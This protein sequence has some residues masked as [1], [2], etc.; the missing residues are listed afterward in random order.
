MSIKDELIQYCYRCLKD[1]YISEFE[2]Y[3]S[4]KKHKQSVERLLRDFERENTEGFP[5]YWDDEEAQKI[6]KWFTYLRHSKGELAGQPINLTVWQKFFVCQIYGWK[7]IDTFRRR[8]TKSFVEC[9]RKQAKSQMEAGIGLYEMSTTATKNNEITENYMTGVRKD[10]SKIIFEEMKLMLRGSSLE[11]RF[12]ISRDIIIHRKSGSLAKPLSKEDKKSGDGTNINLLILD[13]YHQHDT[14]EYY[15]LFQGANSKEPLLMIITTAGM[16]LECPCFTQEYKYCSKVLSGEVCNET[17]F[18]DILE[19]D[20]DDDID[21]KRNW[22]KANPIRMS[23]A[24]GVKKIKESYDIAKEISEKMVSFKTKCLNIWV[25]FDKNSN[26]YLDMKEYEAVEVEEF[27]I[28]LHGM[29]CYVGLD[30]N[31]SGTDLCGVTFSVPFI[32]DIDQQLCICTYSYGFIANQQCIQDAIQ[33][34]KQ[35]YDLWQEKGYIISTES[36]ITSQDFIYNW[37]EEHIKEMNYQN[38]RYCPDPFNS[39]M[40]ADRLLSE[41]K[42]V[43]VIPQTYK[44]LTEPTLNFRN[45]IKTKRVYIKRDDCLRYQMDNAYLEVKDDLVKIDKKQRRKKIDEVDS[46]LCTF[47]L[48]CY[49]KFETKISLEDEIL[50]EDFVV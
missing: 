39:S 42:E 20:E 46:T 43:F 34:Q 14:T 19:L 33:I 17:Y 50:S 31:S 16:K 13:E 47:R 22:W 12:K 38:V 9:G 27:P 32:R 35:P 15:D 25:Q 37:V 36:D 5:Y 7:N 18:I 26:K 49:H 4:C 6:V 24:E 23:Y 8:F 11:S 3:I 41:K 1:E 45:F 2:D 28:E 44:N 29:D 21:D 10:Q 40:Y 48:V 30:F